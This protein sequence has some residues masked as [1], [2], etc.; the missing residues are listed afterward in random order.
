M[1]LRFYETGELNGSSF[2]KK[3]LR[4]NALKIIKNDDELCFIWSILA[5][6][7]PC[8]NDHPNRVSNYN[9]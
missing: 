3:P 9:Q 6:L 2:M 7:L 5:S 4:S 1:K 8:E